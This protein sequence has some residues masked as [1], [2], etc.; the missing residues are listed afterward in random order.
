[1]S[2]QHA[3]Y[4]AIT[5]FSW[6]NY[7]LDEVEQAQSDQWARALA[8]DVVNAIACEAI[9]LAGGKA[10]TPIHDERLSAA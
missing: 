9:E 3:A 2:L 5:E 8:A 6:H 7:K 10:P 4:T 1:M